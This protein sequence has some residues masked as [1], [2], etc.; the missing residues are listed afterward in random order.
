MLFRSPPMGD[1]AAANLGSDC[2]TPKQVAVT[3]GTTTALRVVLTDLPDTIPQGLWCYRVDKQHCLVGG[4]MTEGGNIHAW[5]LDL[6]NLS[7]VPDLEQAISQIKPDSHH[8]TFLPL[9]SG[10]RSPGWNPQA[11][12]IIDGLSLSTTPVEIIRASLEGVC[13]RIDQVYQQLRSILPLEPEITAGGGAIM[14]SPTWL[15]ILADVLGQPIKLAPILEASARGVAWQTL[16][17]LG[18]RMQEY[19]TPSDIYSPDPETHKIYQKAAQ[20]QYRL[21]EINYTK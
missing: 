1:G 20:R 6:L 5:L 7:S 15:Q 11:R 4:A 8:L 12:G 16:K 14:H 17:N 9:L 18:V 2:Y 3:I 10:E 13:Y 19:H 21:Y